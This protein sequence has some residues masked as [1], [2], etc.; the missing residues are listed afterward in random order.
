MPSPEGQRDQ[1]RA[2]WGNLG[3][4]WVQRRSNGPAWRWMAGELPGEVTSF[5]KNRRREAWWLEQEALGEVG[6]AEGVWQ[7]ADAEASGSKRET[8]VLGHLQK[9][10]AKQLEVLV[11][12]S[13]LT[14]WNAMDCT[15][16]G[17]AVH[18]MLQAGIL[19]GVAIPFSRGSS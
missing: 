13:C 17:S 15:L 6:E 10:V 8:G 7:E 1:I 12:Q 14:L 19:E 18:G 16:P 2:G 9:E 4:M 3:A 11:A 5:T